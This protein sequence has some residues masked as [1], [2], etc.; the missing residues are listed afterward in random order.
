M[1]TGF[2]LFVYRW[3]C[4]LGFARYPGDWL[5]VANGASEALTLLNSVHS[6]AILGGWS[7]PHFSVLAGAAP[8]AAQILFY[9]IASSCLKESRLWRGNSGCSLHSSHSDSHTN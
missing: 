6:V 7:R 5:L 1:L 9:Y 3:R 8:M 4:G 2:L